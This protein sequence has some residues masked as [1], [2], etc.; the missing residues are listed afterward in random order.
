MFKN[1]NYSHKH[2][3]TRCVTQTVHTHTQKSIL[4]IWPG[5]GQSEFTYSWVVT[6]Y[7]IGELIGA[8]VGGLLSSVLTYRFNIFLVNIILLIGG[9]LYALASQTWMIIT[10]RLLMGIHCGLGLVLLTSYIGVTTD[11][12]EKQKLSKYFTLLL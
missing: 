9:V 7:S 12:I 11:Q 2:L 8:I 5:L 10:A 1:G 6:I 3:H 4:I